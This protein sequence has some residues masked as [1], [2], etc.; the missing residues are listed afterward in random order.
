MASVD[1]FFPYVQ[2]LLSSCP[3]PLVRSNVLA[4]A[5]EFCRRSRVWSVLLPAVTLVQG[6][7][8]YALT[9]PAESRVATVLEVF[10]PGSG[11]ELRGKGLDEVAQ[12]IPGWRT[13]LGRPWLFVRDAVDEGLQVYPL[14]DAGTAGQTVT[15][16]VALVPLRTAAT[17]PDFLVERWAEEIGAGALDRLQRMANQ[18]WTNLGEAE[19]NHALFEKGIANARI[20]LEHGRVA[21]S[22][23]VAP[24]RFGAM[25]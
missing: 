15:P 11:G 8:A 9:A 12:W 19:R 5:I 10:G 25:G 1:D 23:A 13:E 18:P 2:P 3:N 16:R 24:R 17:V 21:G 7:A 4:A 6:Q 20:A 14:P 22:L